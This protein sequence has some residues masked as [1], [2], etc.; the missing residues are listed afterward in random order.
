MNNEK[1]KN[2]DRCYS[3]IIK[4]P[5]GYEGTTVTIEKYN[6]TYLLCGQC[7]DLL[8]IE[9]WPLDP[10]DAIAVYEKL[11]KEINQ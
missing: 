1:I 9:L 8:N 4:E 3:K 2:C 7:I 6:I 5:N 11:Y 10:E